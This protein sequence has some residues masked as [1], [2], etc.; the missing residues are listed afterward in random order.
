MAGAQKRRQQKERKD[1]TASGNGSSSNDQ[2]SP[3]PTSDQSPKTESPPTRYDGNRD[4]QQPRSRSQS[5]SGAPRTSAATVSGGSVPVEGKILFE[6]G[7]TGSWLAG[8]VSLP[9]FTSHI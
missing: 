3:S 5:A 4:P 1:A 2:S 7:A 9:T 8:G 6:V